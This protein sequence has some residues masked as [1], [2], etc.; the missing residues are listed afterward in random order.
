M[1][2]C[3]PWMPSSTAKGIVTRSGSRVYLEPE[4]MQE[5][6]LTVVNSR[7][8]HPTPTR[9]DDLREWKP[10]RDDLEHQCELLWLKTMWQDVDGRGGNR[11]FECR[12]FIRQLMTMSAC[13]QYHFFRLPGDTSDSEGRL[14]K[15]ASISRR[16]VSTSMYCIDE[17]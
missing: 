2:R 17:T 13:A 16:W 3:L 7:R 1:Q 4:P 14:H 12:S 8:G 15:T 9:I 6:R 5:V 11:S 10:H